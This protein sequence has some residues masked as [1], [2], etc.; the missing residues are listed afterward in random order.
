MVARGGDILGLG[1]ESR[2][3]AANT[4]RLDV[5]AEFRTVGCSLVHHGRKSI[6]STREGSN[7][8][9]ERVLHDGGDGEERL[10]GME[11]IGVN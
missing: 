4:L 9:S 11:K 6:G 3:D 5:G 1:V 10:G 2:R 8:Q 7:A